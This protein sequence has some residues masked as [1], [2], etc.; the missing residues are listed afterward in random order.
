VL[1]NYFGVRRLDGVLEALT[2]K[3]YENKAPS[4]RRTLNFQLA[5]S[6]RIFQQ[7]ARLCLALDPSPC[8]Y[9]NEADHKV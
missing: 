3:T 8:S 9:S 5:A 7:P 4:S 2:R 1:K 6:T